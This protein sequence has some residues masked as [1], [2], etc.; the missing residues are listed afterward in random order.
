MVVDIFFQPDTYD[1]YY[2]Y[3]WTTK[4]AGRDYARDKEV[5]IIHHIKY[6]YAEKIINYFEKRRR[7]IRA[8]SVSQICNSYDDQLRMGRLKFLRDY[9]C[10]HNPKS[11]R[12]ISLKMRFNVLKRDKYR[13]KICGR[14]E[15]DNVKLEI[16]HIYPFSKGGLTVI[17]NLQSLC[18]DCNRGK[19]AELM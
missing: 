11:N 8:V 5:K 2:G 4:E 19:R 7:K 14:S 9:T 6:E 18:F 1:S 12:N 16:D 15:K 17:S 10:N 13:C 3:P